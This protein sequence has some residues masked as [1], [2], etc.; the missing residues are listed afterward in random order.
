VLDQSSWTF[1]GYPGTRISTPSFDIFTTLPPSSTLYRLPGFL[2]RA[3][4]HYT[5]ELADLPEPTTRL[6]TFVMRSRAQWELLTRR[7]TGDRADDYLKVQRGGYAHE[8]K[9]VYFSIGPRDSLR[10][11]AHEGWHQYTQST[12]VEPLPVW[13]EEGV[14]VAMEGFRWDHEEPTR[15]IFLMWANPER[16]DDLVSARAR[17]ELMPLEELVSTTPQRRLEQG[18]DTALAYYA[19]LWALVLFLR[20]GEGGAHASALSAM[21]RD[22]ATGMVRVEVRERLGDRAG[23]SSTLARTGPALLEAYVLDETPERTLRD[24]GVAYE[25]FID[26]MISDRGRS[27][28]VRGRSPFAPGR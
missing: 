8:G 24:L 11:A 25:A 5:R 28:V 9:A 4:L 1:Q 22:S 27:A 26:E 15:P 18:G 17:G 14:S 12:F 23:G 6:E 13:L 16:Y 20:E 3:L 2:G 19:Q 10:I 21:L 7:L